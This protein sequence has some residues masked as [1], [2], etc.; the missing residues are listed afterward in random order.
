MDADGSME[1]MT[2]VSS[3]YE[4]GWHGE[5][6]WFLFSCQTGF[7]GARGRVESFS[8]GRYFIGLGPA[9]L[10]EFWEMTAQIWLKLPLVVSE[11]GCVLSHR[12][13]YRSVPLRVTLYCGSQLGRL[14]VRCICP[15]R[16]VLSCTKGS[17]LWSSAPS[18]STRRIIWRSREIH[19]NEGQKIF[20]N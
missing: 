13:E 3:D 18:K 5:L 17:R 4:T 19:K 11:A 9:R 16:A 2:F 12:S 8:F 10:C 7:A 15:T 20:L 14:A 1:G 6:F